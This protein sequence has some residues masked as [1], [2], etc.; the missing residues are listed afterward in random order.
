[1]RTSRIFG[2]RWAVAAAALLGGLALASS[3]S[4]NSISLVWTATS[5]AGV[6]VG[7]A[8]LTGVQV[9]DTATLDI[10]VSPTTGVTLVGVDLVYSL[11]LTGSAALECPM[12]PN[13]VPGTCFSGAVVL[14]P[15]TPGVTISPGLA[16][17]FDAQTLALNAT[18]VPFTLGRITFTATAAGSSVSLAYGAQGGY[19]NGAGVLLAGPAN[20]NGIPLNN[21]TINVIPEPGTAALMVLGLSVLA[22]AGRRR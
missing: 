10:V 9:G 1:M 22:W 5:G 11:N 6:G 16:S 13:F 7:T 15:I 17:Q 20:P 4:A 21:A 3:A 14:S 18:V 2:A 19:V 12:P 8:T